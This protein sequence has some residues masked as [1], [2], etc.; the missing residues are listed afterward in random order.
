MSPLASTGS[1]RVLPLAV[2]RSGLSSLNVMDGRF[3]F[4]NIF[5]GIFPRWICA[6]NQ[7]SAKFQYGTW[8]VLFW[9]TYET[10]FPRCNKIMMLRR[11]L[12]SCCAKS[13]DLNSLQTLQWREKSHIYECTDPP[14]PHPPGCQPGLWTVGI[15]TLPDLLIPPYC[16]IIIAGSVCGL[17]PIDCDDY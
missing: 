5:Y 10:N 16:N 3:D 9:W 4:S 12:L 14:T 2:K 17:S 7:M 11:W 6:I 13:R 8:L 15:I 1:L